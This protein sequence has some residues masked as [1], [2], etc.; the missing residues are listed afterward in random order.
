MSKIYSV[1]RIIILSE[2]IYYLTFLKLIN[3][4]LE[5]DYSFD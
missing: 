2:I 1:L 5:G 3:Q 4:A